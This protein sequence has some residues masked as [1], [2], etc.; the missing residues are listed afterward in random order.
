MFHDDIY[1]KH[2]KGLYC[3]GCES[4]K[5]S[6]DLVDGRC[7]DHPIDGY[8]ITIEEE[9]YFF[10]LTKYKD[11]LIEFVDDHPDFLIPD[12][13]RTELINLINDAEDISISRRRDLCPWG[14]PVPGDDAQVMYVWFDALMNYIIAA[15]YR[16]PG[17]HWDRVIQ[18]CGPDNLRFQA[19]IFQAFLM[20]ESVK[21]TDRLL[22]HG[23]ITDGSGRK[24]SKSLDNV[25]DPMDQLEKFGLDAVR[26]YAV[27]GLNNYSNSSWSE[28]D[29]VNL[30]NADMCDGF[31]NLVA[32]VLHLIDKKLG[33]ETH[34]ESEKSFDAEVYP[35]HY[36][37]HKNWV[38]FE[39]REGIKKTN[40][41]VKFANN[42]INDK[43]PWLLDGE[44]LKTVLGNL[45]YLVQII[46][47]LYKPVFP[48]VCG[49]VDV[50]IADKKKMIPFKKL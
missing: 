9:N 37:A 47:H 33:V 43:K 45:Y 27:Y 39:I 36:D 49:E 10:K 31:G 28:T 11:R 32:R 14:V 35:M 5:T 25:I 2:Y 6:K 24:M 41:L 22:V 34:L 8:L 17:F 30:F 21:N 4:Y 7:Q 19:I 16:T 44:E 1:R 23:T 18:I 50:A 3:K 48:K 38:H 40:E 13:K 20:S 46:N 42:Y 26:Y 29:L 12:N 15:G